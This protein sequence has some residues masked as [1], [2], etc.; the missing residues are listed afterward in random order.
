MAKEQSIAQ[1]L[2]DLATRLTTARSAMFV[3]AMALQHRDT[4]L[5]L[6]AAATLLQA[7]DGVTRVYD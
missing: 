7:Y 5:E 6:H 1:K 4:D 2:D 3:S